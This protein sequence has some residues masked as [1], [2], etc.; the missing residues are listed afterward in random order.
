MEK[1][2]NCLRIGKYLYILIFKDVILL[3]LAKYF[4]MHDYSFNVSVED[5]NDKMEFLFC[6]CGEDSLSVYYRKFNYLQV[7][8]KEE[9]VVIDMYKFFRFLDLMGINHYIV[10]EKDRKVNIHEFDR[11]KEKSGKGCECLGIEE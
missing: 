10:N 9:S 3:V 11:M 7:L 4:Y 6:K 8:I 1:F 5:L 2:L